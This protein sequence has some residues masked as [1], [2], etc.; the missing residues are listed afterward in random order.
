MT[1]REVVVDCVGKP[2]S[3]SLSLRVVLCSVFPHII[4]K[5][6]LAWVLAQP[7]GSPKLLTVSV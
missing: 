4:E 2:Y 1:F 3:P 7:L 6:L 5:T